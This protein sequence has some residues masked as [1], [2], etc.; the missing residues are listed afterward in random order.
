M[1]SQAICT[2]KEKKKRKE[3]NIYSSIHLIVLQAFKQAQ[4]PTRQRLF[5]PKQKTG[6]EAYKQSPD[7]TLL[8]FTSNSKQV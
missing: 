4:P 5:L 7:G 6:G 8:I 3:I 1:C 2:S